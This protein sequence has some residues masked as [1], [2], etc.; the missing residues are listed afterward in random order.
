MQDLNL[1][2]RHIHPDDKADIIELQDRI[3]AFHL[4]KEDEEK[5]KLYRL[6]R[7][8][9]GQRQHGVQMLRLKIPY[10]K[11]TS[12]QLTA[13]A[14]ISD[15]FATGN[16]HLTTRQNIQLHYVKLDDS[17]AVWVKLSEAG[18]T[19]REAC[20]NTV[21]N[22]TASAKAGIDPEEAFDV[23]PYVQ[24]VFE[25]FLRNPI[26]QEM[27]RKIKPAF[28]SS[29]RDSAY[30]YFSDFGFIPKIIDGKRG[31]QLVIGG[32]LG[33]LAIAAKYVTDFIPEDK[34]I[35]FMEAS[36]RIFDRYGEREKRQKARLKFLIKKLG[37]NKFL[38]LVNDEIKSLAQLSIP[39]EPKQNIIHIPDVVVKVKVED[40]K[41]Q[42]G[43]DQ[44]KVTNTFQ[45]KQQ[46]FYGVF[47]KVTLGDLSSDQARALAKIVKQHA[48]DDIRITINQ[49][50]LLRYVREENLPSLYSK[51]QKLGL[52]AAGAN[53]IVDITA[54]PG[55]DTCNLGVTN[56]TGLTRIL[57]NML[58]EEYG[59]LLTQSD[60]DIKISGCMN[61]CG[62]HMASGIGFHGSSIRHEGKIIPAMQV[63]VGGGLTNDGKGHI[64]DKVIKLPTKRIPDAV[65]ILLQDYQDNSQYG[66]SFI[67]YSKRQG[68]RYF[69]QILKHLAELKE[70]DQQVYF[71]WGQD[72]FYH[73]AI[74]V[75][76]C[77]GVI[78]DV[79]GSILKESEN[80]LNWSRTS[81]QNQAYKDAVYHAYS[82]FVITAK[83]ILLGEDVKCNTQI[84]ILEDFQEIMIT[85]GK[86]SFEGDF[87]SEV[88]KLK[89]NVPDKEFA[90][91]YTESANRFYRQALRYRQ[92]VSGEE[93]QVIES[94][95]KA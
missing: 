39:I 64:G 77:A 9:Y 88:L 4:G 22:I 56:S 84:K 58:H 85:K 15:E 19:A 49:N 20:G 81:L 68:K 82:A 31:F 36:I 63:V 52:A 72:D 86:F 3:Q 55:T 79:V 94:Y 14:N 1:E 5:F 60:I 11:I 90:I 71:D 6:T 47:I 83:A 87:V 42:N 17:P 61:S 57:E 32:G 51:L 8:V 62:Q 50:L 45:Q 13:V 38:T 41:D 74:G 7:G 43:Y 46:L 92:Q 78:L 73:Q 48:A 40:I 59:E 16:L 89:E 2:R 93:K 12:D 24:A 70:V 26:C 66:E 44:W 27:G 23:S 67:Y 69:Y 91:R 95:Y 21:R 18:L 33:A 35:P 65:R 54:C 10:G 80:K 53:T 28:S 37:L 34:I 76:E 29:L 75:G 25:Y 30:T